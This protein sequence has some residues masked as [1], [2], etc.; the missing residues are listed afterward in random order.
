MANALSGLQRRF[1]A[2]YRRRWIVVGH[3]KIAEHQ[4]THRPPDSN[5]RLG[6][7][8]LVGDRVAR[9]R[10]DSFDVERLVCSVA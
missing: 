7:L 4:G 8:H 6:I 1:D 5:R 3:E 10:P 9:R 2:D